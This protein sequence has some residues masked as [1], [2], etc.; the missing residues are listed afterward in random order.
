M[1][2]KNKKKPPIRSGSLSV[3][4]FNEA[5]GEKSKITYSEDRFR[6][7]AE[8]LLPEWERRTTA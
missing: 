2:D 4:G 7:A 6:E 5:I 1:T 3:P 8:S